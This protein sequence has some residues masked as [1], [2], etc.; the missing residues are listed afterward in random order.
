M[1]S[2]A[3]K[4]RDIE[5]AAQAPTKPAAS[6]RENDHD[7]DML[8]ESS[9]EENSVDV[10]NQKTSLRKKHV[11]GDDSS[12]DESVDKVPLN[13]RRRGNR[14]KN[15]TSGA[16]FGKEQSIVDVGAFKDQLDMARAG[17]RLRQVALQKLEDS[18]D[19]SAVEQDLDLASQ[20]EALQSNRWLCA[21]L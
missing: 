19:I 10:P 4:A 15:S 18:V 9:D 20:E 17:L 13:L 12:S 14:N 16:A 1:W 8:T 6:A 2:A 11:F 7:N 3:I 5:I 21:K